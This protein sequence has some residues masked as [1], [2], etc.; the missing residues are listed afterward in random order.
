MGIELAPLRREDE[1]RL[2]RL[3]QLYLHDFS[4]IFGWAPGEDGRFENR[5]L[6]IDWGDRSRSAFLVRANGALAGF[7]LVI[8]GPGTP[9]L[10]DVA[11]FFVVRGLRRRGVGWE[12]ARALFARFPAP[13]QVRVLER[14]PAALAF[15]ERAVTEASAGAFTRATTTSSGD[16][17]VVFRFSTST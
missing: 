5:H 17:W 16:R 14:N 13:W 2:D 4:E 12:A 11:E 9:P 10:M 8:R 6:P 7:A 15:W 1:G 3:M